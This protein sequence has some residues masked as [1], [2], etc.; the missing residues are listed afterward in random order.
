MKIHGRAF[1]M[2]SYLT[3]VHTIRIPRIR[4]LSLRFGK[5]VHSARG[6][7]GQRVHYFAPHSVLGLLRW[8]G[9]EYATT[10]CEFSIVRAVAPHEAAST[11]AGVTPGAQILL[12]VSSVANVRR[13]LSLIREMKAKGIAPTL[14]SPDYW[15][16]VHNRL[17][18]RVA[19]LDYS[20]ATHAAYLRRLQCL[21]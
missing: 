3:R 18:T 7:R 16:C 2:E 10:L 5:P 14:V 21:S 9:N 19:V 8:H 6:A 20:T 13:M 4:H 17:L 1:D 11:M 12:A 15:R